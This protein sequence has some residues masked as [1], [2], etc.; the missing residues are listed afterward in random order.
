[1][2]VKHDLYGIRFG[3]P[4]H[5]EVAAAIEK[6]KTDRMTLRHW[7]TLND[8]IEAKIA[9]K[10]K[11]LGEIPDWDPEAY[12]VQLAL[13]RG[14]LN[15]KHAN[16]VWQGTRALGIGAFPAPPGR[17]HL[18]QIRRLHTKIWTRVLYLQA[19]FFLAGTE[20]I[21]AG[22]NPSSGS[23]FWGQFPNLEDAQRDVAAYRAQL[24]EILLYPADEKVYAA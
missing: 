12:K 17:A 7:E 19:Q 9:S 14:Q 16:L 4:S 10:E 21:I 20:A 13:W 6:L 18:N 3:S 8:D 15:N 2:S 5:K 23:S 22:E 24:G 11:K 1:M